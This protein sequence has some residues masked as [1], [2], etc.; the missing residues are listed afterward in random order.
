MVVDRESDRGGDQLCE[1]WMR[2][3]PRL[4]D[5]LIPYLKGWWSMMPADWRGKLGDVRPN[6][7]AIHEGIPF[8][9]NMRIVPN[10]D[11]VFSSLDGIAPSN[12]K[13]VVIGNDPY[14][15]PCRATGRSFE[16]GDVTD[17]I[18]GLGVGGRVTNSLRSLIYAAAALSYDG[19]C[20]RGFKGHQR[21]LRRA[22]RCGHVMLPEPN[23]MFE[24]LAAQGV[25]WINQTPTISAE[26]RGRSSRGSRWKAVENQ[27][28]L[29]KKFWQP[30][31]CR[32]ISVLVEEA[33]ERRIVFALFGDKAQKL[34]KWIN[35]CKIC[36]NIPSGNV[37]V[38]KSGHPSQA[39]FFFRNRNPLARI[40]SELP[41]NRRI[42]WSGSRGSKRRRTPTRSG[43]G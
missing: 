33:R 3:M 25:L 12:V 11:R 28:S 32:M 22:L 6:L 20:T 14:P 15:D 10:R 13:V 29:H 9:E 23:A 19:L 37:R 26:E 18:E 21:R 1:S 43:S 38:V 17:W 7:C 41:A 2:A 30:V 39:R 24:N 16:Q 5:K 40:N 36:Q 4:R 34:E 27:R 31:M 42:R 35:T 8:T